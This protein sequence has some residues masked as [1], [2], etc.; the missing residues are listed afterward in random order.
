M[1]GGY[2]KVEQRMWLVESGIPSNDSLSVM[3][4]MRAGF[5]VRILAM[6]IRQ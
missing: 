2:P 3:T 1:E 4:E 6:G 5:E